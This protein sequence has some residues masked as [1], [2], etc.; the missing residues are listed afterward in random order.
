MMVVNISQNSSDTDSDK[1]LYLCR[2][3]FTKVTVS[4]TF[5]Q[6]TFL[7]RLYIAGQGTDTRKSPVYFHIG[8]YE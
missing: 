7:K 2:I 3:Y 5:T 8:R 1:T 6:C 4:D